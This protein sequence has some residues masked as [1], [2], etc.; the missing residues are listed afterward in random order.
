[1]RKRLLQSTELRSWTCQHPA[2]V[3]PTAREGRL[4]AAQDGRQRLADGR[5]GGLAARLAA[6]RDQCQPR[7][8]AGA[9]LRSQP[10]VQ[11]QQ[12]PLEAHR[13]GTGRVRVHAPLHQACRVS[14]RT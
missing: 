2:G 9:A 10:A 4:R 13:R 12:P 14:F 8:P 11:L 1:M 6:M 5:E 3:T 7:G